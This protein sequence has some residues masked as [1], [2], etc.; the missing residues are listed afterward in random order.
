MDDLLTFRTN[1]YGL[2]E[3]YDNMAEEVLDSH[4]TTGE[5]SEEEMFK[6]YSEMLR[7]AFDNMYG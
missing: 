3:L 6:I 4:Q 5:E 1:G 7:E 2:V